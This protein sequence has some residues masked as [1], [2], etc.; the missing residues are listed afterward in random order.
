M[1][2]PTT[3]LGKVLPVAVAAS[4]SARRMRSASTDVYSAGSMVS[5]HVSRRRAYGITKRLGVSERGSGRAAFG[6][7]AVRNLLWNIAWP[8]G[9][10]RVVP[11]VAQR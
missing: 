5:S 7:F 6:T 2:Q 4:S 8:R 1:T 10:G 3:G 9:P 11:D